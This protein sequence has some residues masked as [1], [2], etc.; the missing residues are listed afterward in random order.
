[1]D[2][3]TKLGKV[4]HR[5]RRCPGECAGINDLPDANHGARG[6]NDFNTGAVVPSARQKAKVKGQKQT[7]R[8]AAGCVVPQAS[9]P[10]SDRGV[11]PR[12]RAR[13]RRR[14]NSQA[15]TPAV[16][17]RAAA[18]ELDLGQEDLSSQFSCQ[19]LGS[20]GATTVRKPR[21]ETMNPCRRLAVAALRVGCSKR[22]R[23]AVAQGRRLQ[24]AGTGSW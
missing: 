19:N 24:V 1:M 8:T 20:W 17:G 16:H 12:V 2:Q 5:D 21:I 15:R 23:P 6:A 9:S 3:A 10:A 18:D 22:V 4:I 11:P 13:A 14:S 7:R